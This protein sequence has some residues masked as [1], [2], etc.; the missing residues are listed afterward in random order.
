MHAFFRAAKIIM[1]YRLSRL[2]VP[3]Q[4]IS[5]RRSRAERSSAERERAETGARSRRQ[6]HSLSS[7]CQKF[8]TRYVFHDDTVVYFTLNLNSVFTL[9]RDLW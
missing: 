4:R 1:R 6:G 7:T 5:N 8:A 9:S 2:V 3:G